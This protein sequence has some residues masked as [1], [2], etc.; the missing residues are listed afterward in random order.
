MRMF[1][2]ITEITGAG[3]TDAL[4]SILT[5]KSDEK[6]SLLLNVYGI[7]CFN[8]INCFKEYE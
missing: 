4:R 8:T 7:F 1:Q 2:P 5:L 6:T 3:Q